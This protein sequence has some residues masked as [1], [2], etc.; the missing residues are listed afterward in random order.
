ML[1]VGDREQQQGM[2]A[3][4]QREGGDLGAMAVEGLME[5]MRG[6]EGGTSPAAQR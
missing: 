5:R 2:V 3:V 6:E 1:V 4:R